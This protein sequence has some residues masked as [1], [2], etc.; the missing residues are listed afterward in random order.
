MPSGCRDSTPINQLYQE[1]M[2]QPNTGISKPKDPLLSPKQIGI[3]SLLF[4]LTFATTTISGMV[5]QNETDFMNVGKGLMYSFSVL[6]ILSCHEFGHYFAAR[7]HHIKA[8]LPYYIPFIP[9]IE[10]LNFGTL[11]AVIKTKQPIRSKTALFDVGISGPIAG[12]V[13]TLIVLAVGF[14][15]LPGKGFLL[16]I[17]PDYSFENVHASSSDSAGVLTF[18]A[19]LLYSFFA[20]MFSSPDA[21]V[22]PMTEMYHYPFLLAG[23]F[24]L[25]ITALNLL[26]VGQLDGGH[27]LYAMLGEKHIAVARTVHRMLIVVGVVGML[28]AVFELL[29]MGAYNIAISNYFPWFSH[30][31]WSGWLF[32]AFLT[33]VVIKIRHPA[34]DDE[35]EISP[36]RNILGFGAAFIF[37]ASITPAPIFF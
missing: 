3:H 28:P 2:P 26:P 6:F 19:P 14:M 7:Y 15:T 17:H 5:W 24:G 30:V 36:K 8:T 22:P 35:S 23:W 1:F 20:K 16:A 32:W 11:G 31:F 13:A 37:I 34:V 21:F 9:M 29:D 12:F 10:F 25:L 4:L 33:G 18:G 27:I